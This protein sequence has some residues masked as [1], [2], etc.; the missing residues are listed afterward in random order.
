MSNIMLEA[1]LQ[2]RCQAPYPGFA[3]GVAAA[4]QYDPHRSH[5]ILIAHVVHLLCPTG[6]KR[7]DRRRAL[8][9]HPT[10]NDGFMMI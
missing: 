2:R 4:V 3:A 8:F 5:Q 10:P 7:L 6:G 1:E 9:E